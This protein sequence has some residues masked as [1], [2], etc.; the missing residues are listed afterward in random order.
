[1]ASQK[2]RRLAE[3]FSNWL[4]KNRVGGTLPDECFDEVIRRVGTLLWTAFNQ[5]EKYAIKSPGIQEILDVLH[6]PIESYHEKF[7]LCQG[8]SAK[9]GCNYWPPVRGR[10]LKSEAQLALLDRA[11][12][13]VCDEQER[14]RQSR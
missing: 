7:R 6:I 1:M 3:D 9:N 14:A 12:N 4:G 13:R 5:D 10:L 11:L 8:A 2:C